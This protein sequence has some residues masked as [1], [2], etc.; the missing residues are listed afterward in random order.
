MSQ[1]GNERPSWKG[2]EMSE[3]PFVRGTTSLSTKQRGDSDQVGSIHMG[4]P[5][6]N[7][8]IQGNPIV[9]P[10][11]SETEQDEATSGSYETN[12]ILLCEYA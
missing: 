3:L 2:Y 8:S 1:R 12:P 4:T 7:E 6:V 5:V 11:S 10:N 9:H